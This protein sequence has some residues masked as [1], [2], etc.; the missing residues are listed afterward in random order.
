M[1]HISTQV[2]D[3]QYFLW[4]DSSVKPVFLKYLANFIFPS[5]IF[6]KH[7]IITAKVF[8]THMKTTLK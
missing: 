5:H 4:H 7:D 6:T 1:S 2:P 3:M 8:V